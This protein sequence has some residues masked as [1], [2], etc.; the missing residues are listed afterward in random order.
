[1]AEVVLH[2]PLVPWRKDDGRFSEPSIWLKPEILQP[3]TSFKIRGIFWAVASL[4]EE[5]R[6]NG[7]ATVSAGNTAQA[8][9]W[10][11]RHFG[12]T[13]RCLMPETAPRPK[14]EM[15]RAL[16]GEP[17]LVPGDEVFRFLKQH[18][19][20][21]ERPWSEQTFVHPWTDP[22]V[23]AGHASLGLEIADDLPQVETVFVPV[24]GGGL[25]AGVGSAVRARCPKARIIAV[26]PEGC[27]A[28]KAALDRGAPCD[29]ACETICD[30]VGGPLHHRRDVPTARA[31][32]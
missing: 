15:V 2:T 26:E 20:L 8:L 21:T 29:V 19:W 22:L 24:G 4:D 5:A 6:A 11:A 10:A 7:V 12:T 28:L 16:G 18:L 13:A 31:V 25:L 30:G 3:V 1:M 9:A 17:V 32:L 14:I 27:P 23:A